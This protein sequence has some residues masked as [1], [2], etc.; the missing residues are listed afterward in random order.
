ELTWHLSGSGSLLG[1]VLGQKNRPLGPTR[2]AGLVWTGPRRYLLEVSILICRL[3]GG[4]QARCVRPRRGA[5]YSRATVSSLRPARVS[6]GPDR[7]PRN[8]P[9]AGR[10]RPSPRGARARAWPLSAPRSRG[11]PAPHPN[12]S[13]RPR[14]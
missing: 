6:R 10:P 8:R 11:P 5:D 9:G 1:G 3:A 7:R 13:S 12:G 14:A 2:A 4:I